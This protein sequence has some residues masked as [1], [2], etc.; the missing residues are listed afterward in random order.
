MSKKQL[1]LWDK[2]GTL[3]GWAMALV[4]VISVILAFVL[5][6]G[7]AFWITHSIWSFLKF[8]GTMVLII[9]ALGGGLFGGFWLITVIEENK[10]EN[11][12]D[13]CDE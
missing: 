1:H 13:H 3:A 12:R 7:C 4:L 6:F 8:L 11:W 9:I 2:H 5:V 10:P